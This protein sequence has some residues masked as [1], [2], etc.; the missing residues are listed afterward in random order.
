MGVRQG[1]GGRE[2]GDLEP[3]TRQRAQLRARVTDIALTALCAVLALWAAWS[4]VGAVRGTQGWAY[5]GAACALL[6]IAVTARTV[7]PLRRGTRAGR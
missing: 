2:L 5:S 7:G 3:G 1:H 4:V 6:A